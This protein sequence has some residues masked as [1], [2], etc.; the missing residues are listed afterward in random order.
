MKKYRKNIIIYCKSCRK[1]LNKAAYYNNCKRCH[2]CENKRRH[3]LGLFGIMNL[4]H[5]KYCKNKKHYCLICKKKILGLIATKCRS[6]A[7]KLRKYKKIIKKN[8][9]CIN[10]HKKLGITACY[11]KSI[12]CKSCVAKYQFKTKGHPSL[13]PGLDRKYP[14]IFSYIL[15]ESIRKRDNYRCQLCKTKQENYYRKLDVHHIDYNKQNCFETNLITLCL[16]CHAKT[17]SNRDY[18]YAY[19]K[20]IMETNGYLS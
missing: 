11:S 20:Y 12:R 16:K 4:K 5:G 6:C 17:K 7:A 13:I 9:F 2:S 3:K 14:L 19:F 1:K 10:C 18:W 8:C 15:K